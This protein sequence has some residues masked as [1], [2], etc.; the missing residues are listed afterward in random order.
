MNSSLARTVLRTR[1]L[2]PLFILCGF[3]SGCG[4]G[5]ESHVYLRHNQNVPSSSLV[6]VVGKMKG[7]SVVS[8][9]PKNLPAD[10]V[11]NSMQVKRGDVIAV[12]MFPTRAGLKSRLSSIVIGT[13]SQSPDGRT[14]VKDLADK[15]QKKFGDPSKSPQVVRSVNESGS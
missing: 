9:P 3:L 7:V 15:L 13:Q 1:R 6:A 8:L 14:F 10:T 12:V 4:V 2:I 11:L 5:W